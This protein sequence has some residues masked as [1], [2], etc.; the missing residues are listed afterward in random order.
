MKHLD[1]NFLGNNYDTDYVITTRELIKILKQSKIDLKDLEDEELD[2]PLSEYSGAGVIFGRT[3]GVIE[4]ATR[5][6][7]EKMTG[8][9]IENIEFTSL[10]GWEGFRSCELN[11]E[12]ISLKIGVAHGLKEA[13]KM[14]DKIRSG[15]EFYHAIEIMACNGGCI[16]GGGQPKPKKRK[17]T[18]IKRGEG[19]NNID[20]KMK[21]R[22]SH[23][24]E[25]VLKIYEKYLDHPLSQRLMN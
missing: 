11:V 23:E 6:A 21:I 22:R 24:N 4:A 3:G 12:G 10:R 16:G 8:K 13:G 9:R 19:L 2:N 18:I 1:Q 17:E 25:S 14:L 5:T 7:L 15:E 20:N